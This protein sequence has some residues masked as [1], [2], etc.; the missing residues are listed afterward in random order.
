[1]NITFNG[2]DLTQILSAVNVNRGILP[3]RINNTY[4]IPKRSGVNYKDYRYKEKTIEVEFVVVADDLNLVRRTLAGMLDV[5]EPAQLIFSDEPN[6]YWLAIPDNAIDLEEIL[7]VGKGTMRFLCPKPWAFKTGESE[8]ILGAGQSKLTLYNYGTANTNPKFNITFNSDCGFVGVTSP[9]GIIQVGN[10]ISPDAVAVPS[11]E[12]LINT[13]FSNTGNTAWT[14]NTVQPLHINAQASGTVAE[15]ANGVRTNSF[16][17]WIESKKWHGPVM[18]KELA[19]DTLGLNTAD[20]WEL[21]SEFHF[22]TLDSNAVRALAMMEFGVFDDAGV[23]LAGVRFTD[24]LDVD[25]LVGTSLYVGRNADERGIEQ[26]QLWDEGGYDYFNGSV[27]LAKMGNSFNFVLHNHTTGKVLNKTFYSEA[28]GA[29]KAKKATIFMGQFKDTAAY[30]DMSVTYFKFVKHHTETMQDVPNIFSSGDELVI[31][32]ETG[33]VTLNGVPYLETL[34]I[35]SKFFP[36]NQGS[37][38]VGIIFSPWVTTAPTVKATFQ[39]R[40]Y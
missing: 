20:N 27:Y 26:A 16:G 38:E 7:K 21:Y 14:K 3:E 15:D 25:S 4:T 29:K 17:S 18:S 10:K 32:N 36:I 6:Y 28:L 39:E 33:K 11:S 19:T 22:R 13:V 34:D 31:D 12:K 5:A 8:F 35:G 30:N 9:Q 2:E 37:T 24:S 40:Y 23:Y 1:M